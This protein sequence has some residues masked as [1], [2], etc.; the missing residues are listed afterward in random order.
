[1]SGAV[2]TDCIKVCQRSAGY[3]TSRVR[4]QSPS[5]ETRIVKIILSEPL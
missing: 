1:V 4:E 5:L 3:T 2:P